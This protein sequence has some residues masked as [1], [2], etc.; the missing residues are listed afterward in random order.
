MDV[1]I[2]AANANAFVVANRKIMSPRNMLQFMINI[3][4][5]FFLVT[6]PEG[7]VAEKRR[8]RPAAAAKEDKVNSDTL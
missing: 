6:M 4:P 3:S 8:G 2:D 1:R 7:E 5:F